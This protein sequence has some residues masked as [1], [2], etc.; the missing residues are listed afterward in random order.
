[1]SANYHV[2][3]WKCAIQFTLTASFIVYRFQAS[4]IS[5]FTSKLFYLYTKKNKNNCLWL[6]GIEAA[7]QLFLRN[8]YLWE[9]QSWTLNRKLFNLTSSIEN[10]RERGKYEA[11]NKLIKRCMK[12]YEL[13]QSQC[14][15]QAKTKPSGRE[16]RRSFE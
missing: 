12:T 9:M 5:L 14:A 8:N 3:S 16:R 7:N 1:M 4:N 13:T 11:Y 6:S 2:L 10:R 15:V